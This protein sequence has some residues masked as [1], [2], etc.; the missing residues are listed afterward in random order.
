MTTPH[1]YRSSCVFLDPPEMLRSEE[2]HLI[3][4]GTWISMF[5]L[6]IEKMTLL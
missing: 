4:A 3:P 6:Q 5:N 2:N 1:T